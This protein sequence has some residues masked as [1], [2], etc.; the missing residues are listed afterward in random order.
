MSRVPAQA[1]SGWVTAVTKLGKSLMTTVAAQPKEPDN[2]LTGFKKKKKRCEQ[3]YNIQ[4]RFRT[5]AECQTA[6]YQ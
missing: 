2:F 6:K 5:N 1:G 3:D 4:V